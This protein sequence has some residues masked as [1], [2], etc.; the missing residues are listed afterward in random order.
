MTGSTIRYNFASLG[1]LSGDLKSQFAHLEELSGQL[2]R[3][4]QTLA[5]NWESGGAGNYQDA[6]LRW[7]ALFADARARLDGLG[8]GVARASTRMQ[9]TDQRVGKSFAT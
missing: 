1:T 9:E 3:Q 5:A 7:D 6:Q 4:V 8:T 2:K